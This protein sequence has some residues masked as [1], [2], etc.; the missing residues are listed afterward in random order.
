MERMLL[1][2]VASGN[3]YRLTMSEITAAA[4]VA[5]ASLLYREKYNRTVSEASL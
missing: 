3:T 1:E 4:S 5:W 2:T